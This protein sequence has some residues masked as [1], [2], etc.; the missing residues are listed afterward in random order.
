MRTSR[1]NHDLCISLLPEQ[2]QHITKTAYSR[3][4]QGVTTRLPASPTAICATGAPP[5]ARPRDRQGPTGLD[6]DTRY[7]CHSL[8]VQFCV[9]FLSIYFSIPS[10]RTSKKRYRPVVTGVLCG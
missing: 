7:T 10:R 3:C 6:S 1:R 4:D 2:Y 9:G 8:T 5:G